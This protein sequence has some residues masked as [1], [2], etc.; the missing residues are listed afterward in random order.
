MH[1]AIALGF[2][3]F[4]LCL[5]TTPLCRDLFRK[6]GV[7]DRPDEVRKFHNSPIPRVGGVAIALSYA[8]AL[9]LLL[10]FAPHGARIFIR[11]KVL[12][13]SLLVPASLVF[14]TGLVDDL[15]GLKPRALCWSITTPSRPGFRFRS[16][17]S[18]WWPAAMHST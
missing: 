2:T 15:V 18:G 16:A 4:V 17:S 14:A 10:L 1:A 12:L 11:H 9:G 8:L 6:W 3:A 7:V 5:I 13:L